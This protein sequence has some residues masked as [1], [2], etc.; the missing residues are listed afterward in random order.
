M[1]VTTFIIF[2]TCL[3]S[4]LLWVFL[5]G[6]LYFFGLVVLIFF[7]IITIGYTDT[8]ILFFMGAREIKSRDEHQFH[9]SAMQEAYKLAVPL[10]NLYFY[11]GALERAFIL[12][13]GKSISLIFSKNLL[14]IC[15]KDELSAICFELLLQARVNMASKRTKVMFVVGLFSWLSHS[16]LGLLINIIPVKEIRQS[17]MWFMYYFLQPWVEVIFKA[18]LGE[19]YFRKLESLMKKY[20]FENELLMKFGSKLRKRDDIYSLASRK[21]I[22]FSS[23]SKNRHYQNIIT[24]EFLPHEWDLIFDSRMEARA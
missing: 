24:L 2:I 16:V 13:S 3:L 1:R 15:T 21:I 7:L 22:E 11:N 10:P 14:E 20:P 17:L 6:A 9:A 5:S 18:T 4:L 12:Q 19:K 23:L 8:A